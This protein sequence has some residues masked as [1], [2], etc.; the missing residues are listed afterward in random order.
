[1]HASSL[2]TEECTVYAPIR[3]CQS[4]RECDCPVESCSSVTHHKWSIRYA[5][6]VPKEH[7]IK[8]YSGASDWY[9]C[10]TYGCLWA[11][12][13]SVRDNFKMFRLLP[14]RDSY[15][16]VVSP[17]RSRTLLAVAI[18]GRAHTTNQY[19]T[20]R[21]IL[22]IQSWRSFKRNIPGCAVHSNSEAFRSSDNLTQESLK[23][24]MPEEARLCP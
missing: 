6:P 3:L 12:Q 23:T 22:S 19:L 16:N 9:A 14:C 13:R 7:S 15:D 11:A 2:S 4:L 24:Q 20:T 17:R 18:V 8:T 5:R 1:M 21:T 10:A